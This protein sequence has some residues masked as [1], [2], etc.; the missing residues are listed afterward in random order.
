M[1]S[2]GPAVVNPSARA[3]DGVVEL[4]LPGAE[5]IVDA[6]V[7]WSLPAASAEVTGRG[8][9]LAMLLGGLMADGYM[10]E[11]EARAIDLH[12]D[13]DGVDVLLRT[14]RGHGPDPGT[15]PAMAELWA[16][17]G[18]HRDQPLRVRVERDASQRV[19]VHVA[20]VAGF[21]WSA[22]SPRPLTTPSVTVGSAS[23][24]N[25]LVR[26]SVNPD[27]GT[28]AL[29][30]VS[31]LDRLV[32]DGDD[33]DTYNY[34]PPAGDVIV[35]LPEAVAVEVIETGPVRGRLRV[36]R[37]YHWPERIV[38]GTRTGRRDVDVV[39]DL[40]LRAGEELVRITASFDNPCRHHRLRAW[41]PLPA[42][43]TAS[44]AEC[45]F[46]VVERDL[47]AEGGPHERGLATF[48]SRRFVSAGGLTVLHEGLLE[49]ELVDG[50]RALALTLLRATGMLS[51]AHMTYRPNPA[52]PP[53]PVEGPQMLGRQVL[54][55]CVHAGDRDPYALA[56]QAWVPL[57]VVD[58]A[59]TGHR[60]S[61]GSLLSTS[62]AEVSALQRV[63]GSLELRVF[64]PSDDEV[65]VRVDGRSGWLVDVRGRPVQPFD[66]S[67]PLRPRGIATARLH[68]EVG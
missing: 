20:G 36:T 66:G 27:D 16:Q 67:F 43:A 53:L 57:E 59:G 60:A 4:T 68:E 5:P 1:A 39:T 56:D 10:A 52:G 47:S 28:F 17:A 44:V 35:E 19:A 15:G 42:A 22:W 45:A 55:S 38:A 25:G 65:K 46:G 23:L 21:G 51:R 41:F 37:R 54:R 30:Q 58:S 32:D 40:E 63:G 24:D 2:A 12:P 26:V 11:G 61:R 29:A 34:S 9:D 13:S 62:G 8:G 49:Y 14:G 18:A 31:G 48:P 7:V 50:G 64:N 3:R 33:G 6:Q